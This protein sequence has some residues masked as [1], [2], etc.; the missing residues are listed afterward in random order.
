MTWSSLRALT[1]G[2]VTGAIASALLLAASESGLP[3]LS[4]RPRADQGA[5]ENPAG[6]PKQRPARAAG[7]APSSARTSAAR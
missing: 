3:E 4:R 6:Q 5:T 2:T 7:A 1:W